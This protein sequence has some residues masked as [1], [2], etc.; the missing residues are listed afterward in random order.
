M[1]IVIRHGDQEIRT[2]VSS[3]DIFFHF[4]NIR[5]IGFPIEYLEP[6]V[7]PHA[8]I[9]TEYR[10]KEYFISPEVLPSNVRPFPEQ[11][12][13]CINKKG[14]IKIISS[15][16]EYLMSPNILAKALKEFTE[17]HRDLIQIEKHSK[18]HLLD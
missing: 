12:I 16:E 5:H 18:P 14:M 11:K 8:S 9:I 13:D 10:R 2:E 17:K 1:D 7:L 15:N 3:N 6:I 4:D